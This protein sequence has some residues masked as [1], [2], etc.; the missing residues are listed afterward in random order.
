[1]QDLGWPCFNDLCTPSTICLATSLVSACREMR[2]PVSSKIIFKSEMS[3]IPSRWH[4]KFPY[5]IHL[6]KLQQAVKQ[7][8]KCDRCESKL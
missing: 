4:R 8:V 2:T 5:N 1:M 3:N 6:L 7:A